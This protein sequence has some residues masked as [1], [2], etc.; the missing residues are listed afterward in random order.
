[1]GFS[2][3]AANVAE[4]VHNF[5]KRVHFIKWLSFKPLQKWIYIIVINW[6]LALKKITHTQFKKKKE[7]TLNSKDYLVI[8]IMSGFF[9]EE[10]S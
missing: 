6:P 4:N 1:M 5:N 10:G 8:N 3:D 7:K 2:Y 9:V